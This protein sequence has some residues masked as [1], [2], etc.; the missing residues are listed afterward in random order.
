M[1][2]QQFCH[3][4]CDSLSTRQTVVDK[5]S[6]RLFGLPVAGFTALT[7]AKQAVVLHALELH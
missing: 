7:N 4:T 3:L 2:L 5:V 1:W 6:V